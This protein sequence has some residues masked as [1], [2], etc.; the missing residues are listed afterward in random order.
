MSALTTGLAG[1]F[2]TALAFVGLSALSGFVAALAMDL[3]MVSQEEGFTPAYV[4]ASILRGTDPNEVS[5]FDAHVVHHGA[6]VLA[7]VLYAAVY[8]MLAAV[9]PPV[10]AAG[11]ISLVPHALATAAVVGFVYTVFAHVV[12]PRGAERVYEER[13]TAVRGQWLRSS[14]VF[15][16]TL[17][18][19]L[20]LL[21]AGL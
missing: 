1:S 10:V 20:P 18:V 9:V 4:A 8:W 7:G 21:T 15:G 19:V 6:G 12:L 14:F 13:S 3:P 16:L 5:A 2:E 17:A 11:P